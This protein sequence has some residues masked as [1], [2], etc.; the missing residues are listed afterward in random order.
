MSVL[1]SIM[2]ALYFPSDI[3]TLMERSTVKTILHNVLL[4]LGKS[5]Y[6]FS[7]FSKTAIILHKTKNNSGS[8]YHVLW[9]QPYWSHS[10]YTVQ[11]L[12]AICPLS[13]CVQKQTDWSNITLYTWLFPKF[14]HINS[15]AYYVALKPKCV[16]L[17]IWKSWNQI[18]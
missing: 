3:I 12:K 7:H 14:L 16:Q 13:L 1:S 5:N 11:R 6:S 9:E 10:S 8:S 17:L 2:T 4:I 18:N 15:K